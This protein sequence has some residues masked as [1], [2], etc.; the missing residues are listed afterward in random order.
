[1]SLQERNNV[2]CCEVRLGCV[3]F[4]LLGNYVAKGH[5][6]IAASNCYLFLEINSYIFSTSDLFS[7]VYFLLFHNI[8]YSYS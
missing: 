5:A 7:L 2:F 8:F 4:V 3:P 1:M 6:I